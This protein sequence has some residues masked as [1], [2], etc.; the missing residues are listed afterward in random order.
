MNSEILNAHRKI[1]IESLKDDEE[2]ILTL[3]TKGK[4]LKEVLGLVTEEDRVLARTIM[5]CL[6]F[7]RLLKEQEVAGGE[8]R[9][10][11]KGK[12]YKMKLP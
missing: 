3:D 11:R 6:S 5:K 4:F 7:Y 9:L 8:F 1:E 10:K 2:Y 12:T